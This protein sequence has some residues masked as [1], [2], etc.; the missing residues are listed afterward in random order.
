LCIFFP[1]HAELVQLFIRK[2][3]YML[4]HHWSF[5]RK[6]Q[7]REIFRS[8][9]M[10]LPSAIY[11]LYLEALVETRRLK[12]Q[13]KK[14][15]VH[16]T[17]VVK[18]PGFIVDSVTTELDV[19][20]SCEHFH[21]YF[22]MFCFPMESG[23]IF[24]FD[25]SLPQLGLHVM[26]IYPRFDD[27]VLTVIAE[28]ADLCCSVDRRG[29]FASKKYQKGLHGFGVGSYVSHGCGKHVLVGLPNIAVNGRY[30][31]FSRCSDSKKRE[32]P[33]ILR[34]SYAHRN[35]VDCTP[36]CDSPECYSPT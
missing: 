2:L 20:A 18:V 8:R 30:I 14:Y 22:E 7:F 11:A 4:P 16:L 17:S 3:S 36:L 25:R 6:N 13:K 19:Q 10:E 15:P 1:R 31:R 34:C 28:P 27:S 9:F 12:K 33:L 24:H 21:R 35:F 26:A 29:L 32:F 23:V 5:S